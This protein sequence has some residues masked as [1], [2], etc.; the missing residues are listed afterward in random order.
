[1][2]PNVAIAGGGASGVLLATQ[3]LRESPDAR[4]T[5]FEPGELGRGV[6]YATTCPTHQLN[7]PASRMSAFADDPSH[8][9]NWLCSQYGVLHNGGSFV[10]RSVYG[11]YLLDIVRETAATY[12]ERLEHRRELLEHRPEDAEIL[13]LATGNS[14]P[15]EWP[16]A[17][18][19][20]R[21]FGNAWQPAALIPETPG[22][23]VLILGTGLTAIDAVLGLRHNGHRGTIYVLSRRGLLPHEHRLLD[24]PSQTMGDGHSLEDILTNFRSNAN[25]NWRSAFEAVRPVTNDVWRRFTYA[26]RRR[27]L[28]HL[29]PYWNVHRHRMA[30]EAATAIAELLASGAIATIAGRTLRFEE[31]PGALRVHV[32]ERGTD[33]TRTL[34]VQRV[35]N[36]SGPEH[37]ATQLRNPLLQTLL[38]Q[39][40][41]VPNPLEIGFEIAADGALIDMNGQPSRTTYA[42]GPVRFGAL[43]ETTAIPEIR[44]QAKKLAVTIAGL[45]ATRA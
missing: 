40:V 17:P 11:A 8:F 39:G 37:R 3:L 20:P 34:E 18:R 31:R 42:I 45:Y 22:E 4:V 19:S 44:D 2:M 1:M 35:I 43:I 25:A 24:A 26:E 27:F 5:I 6:A 10:P 36:C 9:I 30:P 13:V 38:S 41:L 33:L 7:V 12:G 28:R 14:A 21:F 23:S 16:G 32:R 29:V 15:A